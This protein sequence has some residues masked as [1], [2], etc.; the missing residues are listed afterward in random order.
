M[1]LG[2]KGERVANT[3]IR[4]LPPKSGGRTV[5]DHPSLRDFENSHKSHICENSSSP[6]TA[7]ATRYSF[8]KI[9]T[10]IVSGINPLCLGIPNFSLKSVFI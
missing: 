3:P 1:G 8:S 7:S 4:L 10:P 5:G 2:R 6:L 9:I